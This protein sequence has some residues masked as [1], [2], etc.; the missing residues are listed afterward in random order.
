VL[1]YVLFRQ[2]GDAP[3]LWAYFRA[4]GS[5][6]TGVLWFV[7]ALLVFRSR[8]RVGL[9]AAGSPGSALAGRDSGG[10]SAAA[11]RRGDRRAV[12]D[13]T[14]APVRP[15]WVSS[16]HHEIPRLGPR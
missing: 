14:G 8:T 9:G 16:K 11:S 3:G 10:P 13:P 7:G 15:F 12:P 1:E 2:L 5:L 4:E 6:D